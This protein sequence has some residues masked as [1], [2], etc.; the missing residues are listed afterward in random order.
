MKIHR[1]SRFARP[2]GEAQRAASPR[3]SLP[4]RR[5]P[6]RARARD[7][8]SRRC[9]RCS[10]RTR[11][12]RGARP[13]RAGHERRG[14]PAASPSSSGMCSRERK[15]Q[16]T[17]GTVSSTGG[18]RRS[19]TRRSRRSETPCSSPNALATAEHA[20]GEVDA[21]HAD[22]GARDRDGDST[23]ADG[24]FDDRTAVASSP[25]RRRTRCPRRRTRSTGRRSPLSSRR[26]PR[27]GVYGRSRPVRP[28]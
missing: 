11:R 22:S 2:H 5:C 8:S 1:G 3:P 28:G 16:I 15:G 23:G 19:P 27:G 7:R 17:S 21:D 24:E 10:A 20:R 26:A 4:A 12:R 18:S 9:P 25:R 13:A 14:V 6:P